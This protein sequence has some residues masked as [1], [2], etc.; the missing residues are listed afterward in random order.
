MD[1][2]NYTKVNIEK[3]T[4]PPARGGF[5]QHFANRYWAVTKDDCIMFYKGEN[6]Q[7]NSNKSIVEHI[8]KEKQ[9]FKEARLLEHVYIPVKV[10]FGEILYDLERI[11]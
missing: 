11:I 3:V 1:I 4:V 6:P 2:Q 7:C 5:F 8:G 10:W 9:W